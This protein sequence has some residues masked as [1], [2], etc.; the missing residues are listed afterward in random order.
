MWIK[1]IEK[2]GNK[3]KTFWLKANAR[4]EKARVKKWN[5]SVGKRVVKILSTKRIKPKNLLKYGSNRYKHK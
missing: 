4:L 2:V 3:S 1:E 5:L